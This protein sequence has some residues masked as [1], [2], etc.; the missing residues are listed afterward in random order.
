MVRV[1]SGSDPK[2][3]GILIVLVMYICYYISSN[4]FSIVIMNTRKDSFL[5]KLKKEF[6]RTRFNGNENIT[7]L[8]LC[9]LIVLIC[10]LI[11]VGILS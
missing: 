9:I 5:T 1:L 7:G 6:F 11:V 3:F 4:K 2:F 10:L 8:S